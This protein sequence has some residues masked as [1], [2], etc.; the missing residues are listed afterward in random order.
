MYVIEQ[1]LMQ[2]NCSH[3]SCTYVVMQGNVSQLIPSSASSLQSL[4]QNC[5]LGLSRSDSAAAMIRGWRS[6][7]FSLHDRKD[8]CWLSMTL[9][10]SFTNCTCVGK[11][12]CIVSEISLCSC[13]YVMNLHIDFHTYEQVYSRVHAHKISWSVM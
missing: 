5:K 1:S 12:Y 10:N 4:T 9:L 6:S 8:D 11:Q 2:Y 13:I 3:L 7:H